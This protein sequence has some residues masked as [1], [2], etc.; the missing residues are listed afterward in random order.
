MIVRLKVCKS[1]RQFFIVMCEK[2]SCKTHKF[3]GWHFSSRRALT[4]AILILGVTLT[5]RF[6]F[7]EI[8]R[9]IWEPCEFL[10][11]ILLNIS[12]IKLN[13]IR[14]ISAKFNIFRFL[15]MHYSSHSESFV[16]ELFKTRVF[17]SLIDFLFFSISYPAFSCISPHHAWKITD[18]IHSPGNFIVFLSL[19]LQVMALLSFYLY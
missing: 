5:A 4:G 12:I 1:L 10:C 3:C 6:L 13:G 7:L 19:F 18:C 17:F 2:L 14:Y 11:T 9:R 8:S 16:F 15:S